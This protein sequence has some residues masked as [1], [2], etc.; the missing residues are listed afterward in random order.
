MNVE[1]TYR[2]INVDEAARSMEIVYTSEEYGVLHVGAR[3]PWK[4]ERLE[5]IVMLYNPAQYWREQ[6]NEVEPVEVGA[7]GTQSVP[8]VVPPSEYT[9]EELAEA[10]RAERDR[11]LAECNWTQLADAPVDREVWA[12]YRQLLRDVPQQA[13]FPQE[14]IWPT[15]P[16][17]PDLLWSPEEDAAFIDQINAES[18]P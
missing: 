15:R 2:I 1:Y 16:D 17:A 9:P 10:I 18:A 11:R 8:V 7:E 13:G 14:V 4:G 6:N 12:A 5:D 3:L